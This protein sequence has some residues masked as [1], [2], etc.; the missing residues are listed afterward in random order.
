[1]YFYVLEIKLKINIIYHRIKY[2]LKDESYRLYVRHLH[3][4][5]QNSWELKKT[6]KKKY[7][8]FVN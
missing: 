1:M 6:N 8:K 5:Q 3:W 4:K 7:A 2:V